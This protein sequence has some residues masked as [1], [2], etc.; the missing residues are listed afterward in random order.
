MPFAY[1]GAKHGLASKY[2][3]PRFDTIIEP[4]AGSA[5]YSTAHASTGRHV[6]I[7]DLDDLVI[8]TWHRLRTITTADLDAVGES[9]VPGD[10]TDDMILKGMS[11]AVSWTERPRAIT[12]RMVKDWMS[13]RRRIEAT[14]PYLRGWEIIQGD[15][16]SLPDVEAT[17]FIDPP[18]QPLI[19]LAGKLYRSSSDGIDYAELG[20]W[21]RS[22]KGQVIV[23]EQSPA[24]W[25]P[26]AALSS[27]ANG[28]SRLNSDLNSASRMEV[29]WHSDWQQMSLLD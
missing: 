5:G 28:S 18:Y 26:F 20:E 19:S 25:L 29:M 12:S 2:P 11:G 7:N 17:W 6:V 16:R 4:F 8:D 13:V 1:Y 15:Y 9:L 21:C 3:R 14:V 27:Q 22:R 23:C 24:E 10:M